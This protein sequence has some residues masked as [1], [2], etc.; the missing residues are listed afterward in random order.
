MPIFDLDALA[1]FGA[2]LYVLGVGLG[3]LAAIIRRAV[4]K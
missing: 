4:V 2:S 3:S 1:A